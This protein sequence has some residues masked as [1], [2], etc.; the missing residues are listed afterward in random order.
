MMIKT[1]EFSR[2]FFRAAAIAA[3]TASTI[4]V[5]VPSFFVELRFTLFGIGD[6]TAGAETAAV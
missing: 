2:S 3:A 4:C 6:E 1:I 5:I